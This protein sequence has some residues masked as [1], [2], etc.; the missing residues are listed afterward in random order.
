MPAPARKIIIPE[1]PPV[2]RAHG[3]AVYARPDTDTSPLWRGL[4]LIHYV[5]LHKRKRRGVYRTAR[6]AW[7]V[8]AGRLA[9]SSAYHHLKERFPNLVMELEDFCRRTFTVATVEAEIGLPALEIARE[10]EHAR[11]QAQS[12]RRAAEAVA[13][14]ALF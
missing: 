4:K 9:H 10:A 3:W 11:Q 8:E 12:R 6:L 14:E 13:L 5:D 7:G 1:F 2:F